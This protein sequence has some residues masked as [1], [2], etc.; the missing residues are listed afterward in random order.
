MNISIQLYKINNELINIT[1]KEDKTNTYISVIRNI[2]IIQNIIISDA[3]IPVS[4]THLIFI[5]FNTRINKLKKTNTD[6]SVIRNIQII[7][8]IIISIS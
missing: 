3:G 5:F 7:E 8:N 4:H 2:Q 6:I 1:K